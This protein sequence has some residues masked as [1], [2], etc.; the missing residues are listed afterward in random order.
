MNTKVIIVI[1]IVLLALIV[2]PV[3]LG[4]ISKGSKVNTSSS[5]KSV[6]SI[7][8]SSSGLGLGVLNDSEVAK[9]NVKDDC[10][11][12]VNDKVYNV[13]TYIDQHPG[14]PQKI[15]PYCGKD[16]TEAFS[17]QGGR[18]SHSPSANDMLS[19]LFVGDLV[20]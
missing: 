9:H 18:G 4:F 16:G 8:S 19:T 6:S 2:F 11:M 15:L 1:S 20:K 3:S 14:G 13:T 10:F 12:I 7:S 5:S 17:T